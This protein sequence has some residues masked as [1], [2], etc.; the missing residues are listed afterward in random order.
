MGR[1]QTS[2]GLCVEPDDP[3]PRQR[4]RGVPDVVPQC[5]T[6]D[7]LHRDDDLTVVLFDVEDGDHVGMGQPSHRPRLP[8]EALGVL[9]HIG[10]RAQALDRDLPVQ[11]GVVRA[12]NSPRTTATNDFDHDIASKRGAGGHD[13]KLRRSITQDRRQP[14]G[15]GGRNRHAGRVYLGASAGPR[16]RSQRPTGPSLSATAPVSWEQ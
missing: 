11:P 4:R 12:Q 6:G 16:Q 8:H 15:V 1:E 9:G 7:V 3:A 14:I 5:G 10:V 13:R 2:T